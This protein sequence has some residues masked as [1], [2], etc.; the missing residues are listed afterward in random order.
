MSKKRIA[1][2]AVATYLQSLLSVVLGVFSIRWIYLALGKENFGLFSAV[3]AVLGFIG[4]FNSVLNHSNARFFAL[5]IGEGRKHG[6]AHGIRELN[7]WFNTAFS[8]HL[9]LATFLCS[10]M[11][12]V[13]EYL[14]RGGVLVIPEGME[15]SSLIVFRISL[16]AMFA[17]LLHMPFNSLY[18]AKQL[19]FVRNF[20]GMLQTVL[21][22]A[23]AWW[24]L[25]YHGNRFVVHSA[26][27]TA[28]HL[29]AYSILVGI[30]FRVFPECRLRVSLWFDRK[31]IR[32]MLSYSVYAFCD[33]IGGCLHRSG[34]NLVV[35]ANY[36][37]AANAVIGVGSRLSGKLSSLSKSVMS[38][39][40]PEIVSRVGSTDMRRAERLASLACFVAAF[41]VCLIGIPSLFWA[42]D[43]LRVFLV[44]PPEGSDVVVVFLVVNSLLS[45]S[46]S[47]LQML[48][49]A[50]GK[51]RGL[52]LSSAVLKAS[53]M[54]LLWVLLKSGVPFLASVGIAWILPQASI[55]AS[56]VWFAKSIVGI[57]LRRYV[58]TALLPMSGCIS[59]ALLFCA[60]FRSFS[61][62]SFWWMFPCMAANAVCLVFLVSR[63][64]PDEKVRAMP[65][66]VLDW[67]RKRLPG[68]AGK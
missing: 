53:S 49:L 57:D 9:L 65:E 58:R 62:A 20:T 31:R 63:L 48:V 36:G 43:I 44:N 56:R 41:P 39:I 51:V 35:N 61:G 27:M 18:T 4:F 2:N 68:R 64:H 37:P 40:S 24:I 10:V 59:F 3:G 67:I 7:E 21:H 47:G 66:K 1:A 13:G 5:A 33:A 19:I 60:A 28:V 11:A 14:I 25:H 30:A 45:H 29:L 46:S 55:S 50:S 52:Q 26:L 6:A 17:T 38:A 16:L 23:E 15:E 12:F 8:V 32:D 22:A 54:L 34:F 42:G